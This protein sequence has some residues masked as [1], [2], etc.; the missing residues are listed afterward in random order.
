[1]NARSAFQCVLEGAFSYI[2]LKQERVVIAS[3]HHA[4]CILPNTSRASGTD[5]DWYVSTPGELLATYYKNEYTQVRNI[6]PRGDS[7]EELETSIS[8]YVTETL[9][10]RRQSGAAARPPR[11][12][13]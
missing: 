10:E 8:E 6:V 1:M 3:D 9:K 11:G 2:Y 7:I 5:Q 13:P 12:G 4:G